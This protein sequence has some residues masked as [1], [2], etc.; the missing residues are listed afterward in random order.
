M[1]RKKI[2]SHEVIPADIPTEDTQQMELP[3]PL[4]I[5][6]DEL[7]GAM[8]DEQGEDAPD[9]T[10]LD[11]ALSEL[12]ADESPDV[13]EPADPGIGN[14]DGGGGELG[15][16]AT[17]NAWIPG[18]DGVRITIVNAD[19]GAVMA[20]PV[21]FSNREQ[22]GTVLHFGFVSKIQYRAGTPLSIMSGGGYNSIRP[23]RP[24]PTIISS[25]GRSNIDAIRRY[26]CP[27][28]AVMMAAI[29]SKDGCGVGGG[30]VK[31]AAIMGFIY[32]PHGEKCYET[33]QPILVRHCQHRPSCCDCI[34]R[35]THHQP[36]DKWADRN[37][38]NC[39]AGA[40]G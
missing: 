24:M 26:F 2:E 8:D 18:N 11:A 1:P 40:A 16:G 31:L 6:L 36:A 12:R 34:C 23:T 22:P 35:H 14:I 29:V 27:E 30:D 7:L 3:D 33:K 13:S 19:T 21:D 5:A 28:Y 37:R 20:R 25:G 39:P 38:Q 32:G 17:G 10:P 9:V 4:D 15:T